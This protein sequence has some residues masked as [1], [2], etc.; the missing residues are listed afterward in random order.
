M[1]EQCYRIFV[2]DSITFRRGYYYED[3]ITANRFVLLSLIE[4]Y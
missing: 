3:S 4:L 2:S 1:Q